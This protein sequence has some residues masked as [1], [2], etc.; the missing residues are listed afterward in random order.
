MEQLKLFDSAF[1]DALLSLPNITPMGLFTCFL[2]GF[3]RF[4]PIVALSPFLGSKVL[5]MPTRAGFALFL[6]AVYMPQIVSTTHVALDFNLAFIG[7]AMKEV[8]I[9]FVLSFLGSIPFYIVQC[10]G[11]IIDSMRGSSQLMA[12]DPTMQNQVSPIGILYNYI[13]IYMFFQLDGALL[14]FDAVSKSFDLIPVDQLVPARYFLLETQPYLFFNGVMATLFALSIQ[15]AAPAILAIL[16]AEFF[17][18]IA[19]R[20][21]PQVQISFLGMSLKSLLGLA[22]LWA[23]W[24]FILKN[25]IFESLD[26]LKSVNSVV[27]SLIR[28]SNNS[29]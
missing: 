23:G 19:N 15:L 14:F 3:L 18:G 8:G 26:F 28:I 1:L 4:A 7:Y 11:I 6:S 13:L 21:A 9:G 12:Q 22:L 27:D 25:V 24:Q 16:M 29:S 20:L 5:P 2:L 10:S 17:L